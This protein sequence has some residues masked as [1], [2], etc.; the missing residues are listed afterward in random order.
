MTVIVDDDLTEIDDPMPD[1]SVMRFRCY[2]EIRVS[3]S[4]FRESLIPDD[5]LRQE[6]PK[7]AVFRQTI[8]LCE[9][10]PAETSEAV[11]ARRTS[12]VKPVECSSIGRREHW[13]TIYADTDFD[14]DGVIGEIVLHQ[15]DL[16]PEWVSAEGDRG[17]VRLELVFDEELTS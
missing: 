12:L 15:P 8:E 13:F 4:R 17:T 11:D 1:W 7:R 14:D 2:D 10:L 9:E 16:L 3:L 5:A 6:P